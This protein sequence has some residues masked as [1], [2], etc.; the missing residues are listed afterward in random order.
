VDA[1][2]LAT[3]FHE[4]GYDTAAFVSN[5]MLREELGFGR[6]FDIYDDELPQSESNRLMFERVAERTAKRAIAWIERPRTRPFFAWVHFNDPHGPYTPPPELVPPL[7]PAPGE[8]PLPVVPE[9]LGYRGIPAYQAFGEERLPS[10]YRARYAGEVRVADARFGELLDALAAT[11]HGRDA[12]VVLTADHGGN[13]MPE[14][15]ATRGY[16]DATRLD[17][18]LLGR[19]NAA[20][21]AEFGLDAEP[22]APGASGLMVVGE[23]GRGLAEPLRGRI[24]AAAVAL[25][26]ADAQVAGAWT[27]AETLASPMPAADASPQELS[28]L[29]RQRLSAVEDRSPDIV[30]AYDPNI[31]PGRRLRSPTIT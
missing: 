12:L 27:L 31:T 22:L 4:A 3:V 13:D 26:R 24:A 23:G 29:Q 18:T 14:R 8:Q 7:V 30:V 2:T 21:K 1:P 19:L 6:G 11:P 5:M 28:L 15:Q 16:P 9:Q 10:Q 25:L 17:P 20:L